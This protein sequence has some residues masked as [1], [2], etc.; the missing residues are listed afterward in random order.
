MTTILLLSADTGGGHQAAA[1]AIACELR[2]QGFLPE[3]IV[4]VD[5][6][7]RC[8]R[9]PFY[10]LG[11]V[12]RWA[13]STRPGRL[14]HTLMFWWDQEPRSR[15]LADAFCHWGMAPL[16]AELEQLYPQAVWV[17]LH[18]F[19]TQAVG[20]WKLR[21]SPSLR[22]ATVVTELA[23]APWACF[24]PAADLC[25]VANQ[26]VAQQALRVGVAPHKLRV[27]GLP[28]KPGF[29]QPPPC[30]MACRQK[31]GL[32]RQ[33]PTILLISGG[34]GFAGS[35]VDLCRELDQR[36]A[37]KAQLLVVTGYNADLRRQLEQQTWRGSVSIRGFVENMETC[38]GAAD[39]VLTKSGPGTLSEVLAVGRPMILFA[40]LP[41]PERRN[42]DYLV[43]QGA[44]LFLPRQADLA[45]G[46]L[47][48]VA[49]PPRLDA[50]RRCAQLLSESGSAARVGAGIRELAT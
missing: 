2:G 22:M 8:R 27:T 45:R 3:Q 36:L 12:H 46:V 37:S 38:I 43:S 44:A 13:V 35:I 14:L 49:D 47:E 16:F 4:I 19:I 15:G 34:E 39:L 40:H 24:H 5:T 28:L 23:F 50:M 32:A 21:T 7:N 48:L 29:S 9:W 31:L 6:F 41:G 42:V 26:Q 30:A 25:C 18:P 1:Q 10:R 17:T 11:A 33:T 20:R